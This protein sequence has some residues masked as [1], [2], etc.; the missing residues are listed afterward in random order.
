MSSS[1][2]LPAPRTPL[3]TS[4]PAYRA[5][6]EDLWRQQVAEIIKLSYEA[7][8]PGPG[9]AT[10]DAALERALE[11]TARR[12]AVSR[13]QLEETEAALGRVDDGS[14]GVCGSCRGPITA[15]RLEVLPA[16]RYCVGCDVPRTTPRGARP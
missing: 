7:L 3:F 5:V 16:A 2:S 8:T 4:L 13:Q 1:S 12:I 10:D 14:Y 15:E 9:P 6:L 11:V